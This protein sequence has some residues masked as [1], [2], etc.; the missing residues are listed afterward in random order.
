[1]IPFPHIDPVA[2]KVGPVAVHWYGLSYIVGIALGWGLLH[3]RA[4]RSDGRWTSEQVADLVFY[5]ALGGVLGGRLGYILFYNF[6][7]YLANPLGIFKVWQ[8]GM[9]FHGGALGM[10]LALAWYARAGKRPFLE[11]ADFLVPV[12]PIGLGLGRLANFVNQ[13]LW[14]APT[15]L[16]WG[17]V[18]TNPAAGGVA[19]HPSQIYEALL[20]G[21]LLFVILN[22]VARRPRPT[23][24][25]LGL[26]L[27]FYGLFRFAVEFVREPDAH[28]GYLA[29][30][31]FTMGQLLSLPMV[32][33]GL[34]LVIA[35]GRR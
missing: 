25:L 34:V 15:T 21:L 24:M 35:A 13:E 22:L 32:I 29:F 33:I 11:L 30:D 31:W 28:I 12:I 1:M 9:S 2:F 23:G 5:A 17:V 27:M 20:E 18:F 16:P 14:G 26:F 10:S 7:T 3:D 6:E 19:R 4:A 8:G